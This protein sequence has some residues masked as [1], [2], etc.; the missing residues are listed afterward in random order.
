MGAYDS[1]QEC[2]EEINE[3]APQVSNRFTNNIPLPDPVNRI[4]GNG[5]NIGTDEFTGFISYCMQIGA[6]VVLGVILGLAV[7]YLSTIVAEVLEIG[8]M[9]MYAIQFAFICA[10][11]WFMKV[12]SNYLY[13][14]WEGSAGYG[15]VFMA[16]FIGV[17]YNMY[18]LFG[19]IYSWEKSVLQPALS[20]MY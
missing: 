11:L 16:F 7:N 17:Q 15:V 18:L 10:V 12:E 8:S 14:T 6:D 9:G 20:K 2:V 4:I 19:E 5:L 13:S 1:S 3:P